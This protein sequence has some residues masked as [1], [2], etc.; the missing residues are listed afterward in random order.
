MNFNL[1]LPDEIGQRA[2]ADDL[3][4]SRMLRKAVTAEFERRDAIAEALSDT[5][6][7]EFE[8]KTE[9]LGDHT[10]R[11]TGRQIW[12][13]WEVGPADHLAI[14]LKEDGCVVLVYPIEQSWD[15]IAPHQDLLQALENAHVPDRIDDSSM[16]SSSMNS[17]AE[18]M[19][20]CRRLGVRPVIDL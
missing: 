7:Y 15:V 17:V 4:L 9:E 14:Y 20:L 1:Y 10:A 12:P 13:D 5:Q 16:N 3:N 2:K 11:I 6:T 18:F 19:E 8:W